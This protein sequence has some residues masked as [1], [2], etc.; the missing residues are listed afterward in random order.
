MPPTVTRNPGSAWWDGASRAP[1]VNSYLVLSEVG[2]ERWVSTIRGNQGS[3]CIWGGERGKSLVASFA[4]I[5]SRCAQSLGAVSLFL[6]LLEMPTRAPC[7][8]L[9][10]NFLSCAFLCIYAFPP[11]GLQDTADSE[12]VTSGLSNNR[13]LKCTP[14]IC[15]A[16]APQGVT[17][18]FAFHLCSEP[19]QKVGKGRSRSLSI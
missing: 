10:L 19:G 14:Y 11:C 4:P 12:K 13:S 5:S 6:W 7:V 2:H 16:W 9:C 3:G 8:D 15:S 17:S 1:W 18:G